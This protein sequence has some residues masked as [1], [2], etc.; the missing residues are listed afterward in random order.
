MK[1]IDFVKKEECPPSNTDLNQLKYSVW[2]NLESRAA[3]SSSHKNLESLR[4]TLM[5]EWNKIP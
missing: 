5:A 3:C 1:N 4:T 2:A